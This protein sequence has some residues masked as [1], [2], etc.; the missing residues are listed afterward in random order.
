[1]TAELFKTYSEVVMVVT[2]RA[3]TQLLFILLIFQTG[4]CANDLFT[5]SKEPVNM[6]TPLDELGIRLNSALADVVPYDLRQPLPTAPGDYFRHPLGADSMT[7]SSLDKEQI[8]SLLKSNINPVFYDSSMLEKI[9][10]YQY[11]LNS[12]K[13]KRRE[14]FLR[15]AKGD[16]IFVISGW[17]GKF[18]SF[19]R[20]IPGHKQYSI[21]ELQTVAQLLSPSYI[22]GADNSFKI[23]P[24]GPYF[25]EHV[26]RDNKMRLRGYLVGEESYIDKTTEYPVDKTYSLIEI[27]VFI[28]KDMAP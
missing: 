18:L 21:R 27:T 20:S 26:N 4:L 7:L 14:Y 5:L 22:A 28:D 24:N 16:T 2:R 9:S 17:L 25:L 19:Y 11:R 10:G 6:S 15:Y 8:H 13:E 23:N 3:I 12:E 1:M